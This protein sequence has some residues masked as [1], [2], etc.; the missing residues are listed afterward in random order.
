LR[1]S[2][3]R[4]VSE[5]LPAAARAAREKLHH[6]ISKLQE[7]YCA[8]YPELA[9]EYHIQTPWDLGLRRAEELFGG[10]LDIEEFEYAPDQVYRYMTGKNATTTKS[11]HSFSPGMAFFLC[12]RLAEEFSRVWGAVNARED[13]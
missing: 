2:R 3:R 5:S 4:A 11:V 8:L 13:A 12:E 7:R 6:D 9:A 1:P 10:S